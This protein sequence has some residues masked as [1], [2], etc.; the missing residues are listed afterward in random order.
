MSQTQCPFRAGDQV[1]FTPSERT[2]GLYQRIESF[3]I[4]PG[5]AHAITEVRDGTYLYFANG[6]GGWPW[7]EF[8]AAG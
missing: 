2:R 5:D 7:D 6:S 1:R 4:R 8:S 3:G